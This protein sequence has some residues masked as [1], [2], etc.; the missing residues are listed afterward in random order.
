MP[1]AEPGRA[2]FLTLAPPL[3]GSVASRWSLTG[4]WEGRHR[5]TD[6]RWKCASA[7][8]R[9]QLFQ[10]PVPIGTRGRRRREGSAGR[11]HEFWNVLSDGPLWQDGMAGSRRRTR[12]LYSWFA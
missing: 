3:P 7:E 6:A 10:R 9:D 1:G 12:R 11:E 8:G 5:R 2:W 4:E